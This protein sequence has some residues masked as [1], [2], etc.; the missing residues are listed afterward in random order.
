MRRLGAKGLN[1]TSLFSFAYPSS[2]ETTTTPI[3]SSQL[4]DSAMV[5]I[6]LYAIIFLLSVCGN[7]LVILTLVQ[8]SRMR[9][10]TNVFLLNL[11]VSDLLL[12]VVCM[13]F[14]L[15]GFL[16][17]NFIFGAA[18]CKI[19]PYL[20]AVSVSVSAWTL[21]VISV[22]RYYG[23]CYPLRSRCWRSRSHAYH[24]TSVVWIAS[25]VAMAPIAATSTLQ[26]IRSVLSGEVDCILRDITVH[27]PDS[28]HLD[29]WKRRK[30]TPAEL[31]ARARRS[32][33]S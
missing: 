29:E 7:V 8:N 28:V 13:P 9:T 18:M 2:T 19:I 23:I 4:A 22:E 33:L 11:A 21:V 10:P 24:M 3:S 32:N 25:L 17:R 15:S 6:P 26:S 5:F 14:T 31:T 1:L 20:Q 27:L 30:W 16:L 12:G